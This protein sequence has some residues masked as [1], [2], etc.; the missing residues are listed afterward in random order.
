M[1]AG[2]EKI[3][4]PGPVSQLRGSPLATG[5][6]RARRSFSPIPQKLVEFDRFRRRTWTRLR[7]EE[8]HR[9]VGDRRVGRDRT[10]VKLNR[11]TADLFGVR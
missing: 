8:C 7:E 11:P 2:I 4:E 5:K 6:W 10:K 1:T 3:E 9:R